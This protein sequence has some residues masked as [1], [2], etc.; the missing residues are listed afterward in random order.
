M[1]ILI[2]LLAALSCLILSNCS[3][4]PTKRIEKHPEI[5]SALGAQEQELVANGEIAEGMSPE[6][7]FLALGTPDRRLEGSADGKRTMR[8]VYTA[9]TPVYTTSFHGGFSTGFRRF[10]GFRGR[11][12][13]RFGRF[14]GFGSFGPSVSY[15][16][17]PFNSV[18]FENDQVSSWERIR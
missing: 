5:Y 6:G 12:G 3:S 10:G 17:T 18:W 13:R 4:T 11:R 7:V 9:L 14:G 8:W 16:S 1:K 2:P 15:I